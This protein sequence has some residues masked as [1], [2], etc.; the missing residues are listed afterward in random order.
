MTDYE[1]ELER[2]AYDLDLALAADGGDDC[3]VLDVGHNE[4]GEP[5]ASLKHV[6]DKVERYIAQA[7]NMVLPA[8]KLYVIGDWKLTPTEV[9]DENG[10]GTED[11]Q[12]RTDSITK[13]AQATS[14]IQMLIEHMSNLKELTWISGL[15]FSAAV[16][17]S[18][19]TTLV[20]LVLDLGEPVRLDQDGDVLHKSYITSTEMKPLQEQTELEE[21]RLFRVRDS[22]QP[23]I[24]E[25][26]FRNSRANGMRVLDV[27]MANAPIVRLEQW[28]TAENVVGLTVPTETSEVEVYKGMDGKGILHYSIG[29]GEYLDNFCMRKARIASGLD[30]ASPLPL[31]C[32]KLDGFVV[33]YLPF[34][35]ELSQIVLLTCGKHCVDSGLRAPK[36]RVAPQNKWSEAVNNATTHCYIQFPKWTGIFNEQ[37]DQR[38]KLGIV[39]PQELVPIPTVPLTEESLNLKALGDALD[40]PKQNYFST[41]SVISNISTR[42]GSEVPTPTIASSAT[43]HSPA[44]SAIDGATITPHTSFGS[45]DAGAANLE[46]PLFTLEALEPASETASNIATAGSDST[47]SEENDIPKKRRSPIR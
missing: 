5:V 33:D 27:Q 1:Y 42:G 32:L 30:E 35:H 21:L 14:K 44:I 43:A 34:E 10:T 47:I 19:P 45:S 4:N 11:I 46:L 15:P 40:T 36:S 16:W 39:V 9:K 3:L 38:N 6:V 17:S 18:L 8:T 37:G 20:K 7:V 29:T 31:W 28:K 26:V 13:W 22:L 23:L 2:K 12:E 25:T 24:W 41:R